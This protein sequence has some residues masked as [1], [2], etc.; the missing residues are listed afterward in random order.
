MV[1]AGNGALMVPP[2]CSKQ[3]YLGRISREGRGKE[4]KGERVREKKN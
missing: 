3:M 4:K 2:T 1:V